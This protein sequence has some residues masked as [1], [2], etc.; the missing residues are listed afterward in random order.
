MLF[1]A[2]LEEELLW[3]VRDEELCFRELEDLSPEPEGTLIRISHCGHF[4]TFPRALSGALSTFLHPG[5]RTLIGMYGSVR[6]GGLIF[7]A[8]MLGENLFP[9]FDHSVLMSI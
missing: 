7:L 6:T 5:Q 1:V 8:W 3:G 2:D 9:N 4:N